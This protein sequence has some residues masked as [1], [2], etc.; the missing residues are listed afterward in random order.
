[1]RSINVLRGLI[2][3][4]AA[5]AA[6]AALAGFAAP[7]TAGATPRPAQPASGL[8]IS[9]QPGTPDASPATQISILGAAPRQIQSVRVT[10]ALSGA[11]AG[12][13]RAYSANRGA[14]FVL[15]TPLT[16]GEPVAVAIRVAGRRPIRFAFTVARLAPTPPIINIPTTQPAKLQHFVTQPQLIPPRISVDRAGPARAG[17]L[18]LAPLPS[19]IVHPGSSTAISINPVGP[20]GPMIIDPR[21]RLVWFHQLTAPV[22]ATNFRPQF[23]AGRRVLTWWQ[24]KVTI[25]AYGLGAEMIYDTSYRPLR[26]VRAGN[27]YAA[28]LHEFVLTR[29]GDALLTV[30]SLILRHR[31][32]T[33]PGTLS[34]FLDSIVQEVDVRTGLVVWEWHALGHIPIAD[35]YVTAATSPYFDA[36]HINSIELVRGGRV[37]ISARDTS[38]LYE[39]DQATGRLVWTLG[40]K[41]SSFRM[42]P[43]ARFYF[44]HDARLLSA[45][46][47]S[48]FDD[49]G[50]PPFYARSSRGL[51]LRLDLRRRTTALVRQYRRPGNDTLADSE[52]SL[53]TVAGGGALVGFGSEPYFSEF[54]PGGAL[55][56]DAHLPAGDGSYR[57]FG[58]PWTATPATRP[59]L[60]VK[61]TSPTHVSVYASWNGATTVAR[62]QVLAGASPAT[63][64]RA[65]SVRDRGFETRIG[66]AGRATTFAVRALSAGGRVL[67]QSTPVPAS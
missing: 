6:T 32:G 20:G 30:Q 12:A 39:I 42:G 18:F 53:Q 10:G 55:W 36:Y 56:F 24:G 23:L 35:S 61:R 64:R 66:V 60:T 41:A 17:D 21:G 5:V 34:P 14:S 25:A 45:H 48:L 52:G 46:R 65:A 9:P 62:W 33:A 59:S 49:E 63:L 47:V 43:G 51:I 1:M 15:R 7:A 26:V 57:V 11:H 40:G 67:A 22:V 13:L 31:A 54:G 2:P 44:Q 29:S 16:P 19:P 38:A 4:L 50:G 28:D 27:G 3:P 8:T 37:L 58:A